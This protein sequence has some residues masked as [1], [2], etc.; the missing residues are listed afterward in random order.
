[1]QWLSSRHVISATDTHATT[2]E[3]FEAVLSVR[4]MSRLY[5]EGQLSLPVSNVTN[6]PVWY[7]LNKTEMICFARSGLS[8][9]LCVVQKEEL[10]C[11]L[12]DVYTR[13]RPSL[14]IRDKPAL[15]SERM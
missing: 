12:C 13:E 8:E 10:P 14:F 4:S 2:E 1:M 15:S 7:K 3:V 9:D 5:N 6:L 11:C